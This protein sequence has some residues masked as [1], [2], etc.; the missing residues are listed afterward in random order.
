M[1]DHGITG[2]REPDQARGESQ[3]DSAI[4]EGTARRN[5]L[6]VVGALVV[7]GI[8]TLVPVVSAVVA[9]FDP[10]KGGKSTEEAGMVLVTKLPV[11]PD[12]GV[13][14]KFTVRA[15]LVDAWTTYS[16]TPVGAVYLRRTGNDVEALNVVCP[17]AGCFVNVAPDHT[18]FACPCHKSTFNF[19]GSILDPAS[20]SPR[21][22]DALAAEVRNGDEVWVR[23][24]NF[25]TG[26]KD[27]V[28]VA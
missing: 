18:H 9:L 14:R 17:H 16:D 23:F 22:M 2:T 12:D 5:F 1:T 11:L 3:A 27:K 26:R 24:Q 7:G 10:L 6:T 15:D 28:P 21:A 8:A 13:P 19:D 20:P 25:Q 4:P